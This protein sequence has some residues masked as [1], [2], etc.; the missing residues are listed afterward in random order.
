MPGSLPVLPALHG[1]LAWPPGRSPRPE[2]RST[3][4]YRVTVAG[5]GDAG[6]ARITTP[7]VV[8]S[9]AV[10]KN[11]PR[12]SSGRGNGLVMGVVTV[13]R[14]RIGAFGWVCADVLR[15]HDVDQ[16]VQDRLRQPMVSRPSSGTVGIGR[17]LAKWAGG[18]RQVAKL[19]PRALTTST[20]AGNASLESPFHWPLA[21]GPDAGPG[22]S[23]REPLH[24]EESHRDRP[25]GIRS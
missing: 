13:R 6:S 22:Q 25:P 16:D 4:P 10:V 5:H 2:G 24:V 20:N 23:K 1:C 7:S 19:V 15:G 12:N 11:Q 14:T 18:A 17:T 8:D 9:P 21:I 3:G